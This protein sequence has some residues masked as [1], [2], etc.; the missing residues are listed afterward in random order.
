MAK[1][2]ATKMWDTLVALYQNSSENQKVFLNEKMR[3]TR[4]QK[5]GV[6]P[7]L[8]RTQ[9]IHNELLVVG[10]TPQEAELVRVAINGFTEWG[11]TG[12]DHLPGWDQLWAN[13]M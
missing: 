13:F 7:Y 12:R 5:G 4:M 6:T 8:T 10:E 9:D 11:I 2:T 1:N 3:T